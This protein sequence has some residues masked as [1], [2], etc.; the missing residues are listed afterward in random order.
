MEPVGSLPCSQDLAIGPF[1]DTD[2]SSVLP[3]MH[4]SSK[5]SLLLKSSNQNL[6]HN[7]YSSITILKVTRSGR[8]R[9][10]GL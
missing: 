4:R 1:P 3:S 5:W 9:W 6:N 7:L 8:M 2:E 10:V